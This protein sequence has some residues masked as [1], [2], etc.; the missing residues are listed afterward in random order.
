MAG[1]LHTIG[2]EFQVRHLYKGDVAKPASVTVGLYDDGTDALTEADDL[3][4]ITTEPS[5][6]N[7]AR[8]AVSLDSADIVITKNANGNYQAELTNDGGTDLEFDLQGTTGNINAYFVVITFQ[9]D[10]AGDGSAQDHIL[11]SK[12]LSQTYQLDSLDT[13]TLDDL[14]TSHD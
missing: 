6:G 14:S 7:Y 13:L 2:E 11:L 10:E 9:S 12:Q 3:S 8:Q 5:D 4:A 1:E